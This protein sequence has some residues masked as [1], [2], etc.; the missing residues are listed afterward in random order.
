M[1]VVV[2]VVVVVPGGGATG[3]GDTFFRCTRNNGRSSALENNGRS[4][5]CLRIGGTKQIGG[6]L[7]GR[8]SYNIMND[9]GLCIL[10]NCFV[11][12]LPSVWD[13]ADLGFLC[14]SDSASRSHV[15]C[16]LCGSE[17]PAPPRRVLPSRVC[18]SLLLF[19]SPQHHYRHLWRFIS[20]NRIDGWRRQISVV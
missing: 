19:S 3:G 11:A 18:F 14:G 12:Q 6:L 10:Q 17:A 9:T 4:L 5:S 7:S 8:R 13:H 16:G 15:R 20:F 2:V 1:M